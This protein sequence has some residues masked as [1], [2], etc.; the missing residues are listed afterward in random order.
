MRTLRRP[1]GLVLSLLILSVRAAAA[2]S[3]PQALRTLRLCD[4]VSDPAGLDPHFVFDNKTDDILN[5]IYEGLVRFDVEGRI[6][7]ALAER[8]E[9]EGDRS[10]R[11]FLR[12]NI[13]FH[14]GESLEARVVEAS[15]KRELSAISPLTGQ[16]SGIE[17]I[18]VESKGKLLIRTR[19]PDA[20]LLRRLASFARIVPLSMSR[21]TAAFSPEAIP[22]G[23]GPFRFGSWEKG[24]QIVLE[25][26]PDSWRG[27]PYF[28]RIVFE[29][30]PE[31]KQI[32]AL[33]HGT[34]DLLTEVP[35]TKTLAIAQVKG[36]QIVKDKTLSTPAFWFTSLRGPLADV[37]VRQAFNLAVDKNEL[38]RYA[39]MGNGTPMATLSMPGEVGHNP[40]L[41][42][43]RYDP[44]KARSLLKEAGY[45]KDFKL[46]I[47]AVQQSEREA[48]IIKAHLKVVGVE[49]ELTSVSI[50]D[51]FRIV[52]EGK[53]RQYD[54]TANLAPDPI[55][56][57][58]FLSGVCFF[59]LSPMS[60]G[61]V[62]GFDE[63]YKNLLLTQDAAKH[64]DMA[65][66]F[67]KW[68]YEQAWGIYTYQ[69][70]RTFGAAAGIHLKS[71]L[72]GM[73][74][75]ASARRQ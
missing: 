22:I 65:E 73:L 71:Q 32:E 49:A 42:P 35:G 28:D 69:R 45:V 16:I 58:A 70:I 3:E 25:V 37:R 27:K 54:L 67:D 43:Y 9:A 15:L 8:W 68:I 66:E 72:T 33:T 38:I 7:P 4:D 36:L 60:A 12:K 23:T 6:V 11:F 26:N 46:R 5:Q 18:R 20:L 13:K 75:L 63:R 48:K 47:L 39:A 21:S 55:G 44:A 17:D 53:L 62:P 56:H 61:G 1:A 59:S 50:A 30:I 74:D 19:E 2:R 64:K 14:N 40:R 51:G 31:D 10:I 41:A 34:V 57:M 24:K 52:S 29:F